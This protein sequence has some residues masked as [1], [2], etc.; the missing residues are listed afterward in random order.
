MHCT[1]LSNT[2]G[3][4]D[5]QVVHIV[6][7]FHPLHGQPLRLV[8]RKQLWG[9]ERVTVELPDGTYRSIP[10]GWTDVCSVDPYISIGRGRSLFQVE[11]LLK[12][13][14]LLREGME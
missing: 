14:R 5:E 12:L 3:P 10:V 13:N 9:E 8:V 6:H 7:P 1:E 4:V 2:P 11:D